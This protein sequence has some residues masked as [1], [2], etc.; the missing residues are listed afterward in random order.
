MRSVSL[1]RM[2]NPGPS[3][4]HVSMHQGDPNPPEG[5]AIDGGFLSILFDRMQLKSPPIKTTPSVFSAII[6]LIFLK[7]V[8]LLSF[9]A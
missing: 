3:G 4:V 7:N 8:G 9:G 1:S 6:S 2:C 5:M